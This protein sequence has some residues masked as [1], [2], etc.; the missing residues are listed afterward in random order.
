MKKLY[1]NKNRGWRGLAEADV[2]IAEDGEGLKTE[3]SMIFSFSPDVWDDLLK[4]VIVF[5]TTD[6]YIIYYFN[7]IDRLPK[8]TQQRSVLIKR[9]MADITKEIRVPK[10]DWHKCALG[11]S[12]EYIHHFVKNRNNHTTSDWNNIGIRVRLSI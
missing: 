12:Y 10:S 8:P 7:N 1:L 4:G 2:I 3:Q 5:Q 9:F 6:E 11:L